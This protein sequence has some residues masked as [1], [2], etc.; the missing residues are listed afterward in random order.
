MKKLNS[1]KFTRKNFMK[2][3]T[4]KS[5]CRISFQNRILNKTEFEK[6]S[7]RKVQ[8]ERDAETREMDNMLYIIHIFSIRS[9][10]KK[11]QKK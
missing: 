9:I 5:F 4:H 3:K 1:I 7:Y 10:T 2:K 6:I 11:I 8:T